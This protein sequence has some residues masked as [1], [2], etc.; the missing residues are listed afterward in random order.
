V[1]VMQMAMAGTVIHLVTQ[2][3][4]IAGMFFTHTIGIHASALGWLVGQYWVSLIALIWQLRRMIL[5]SA[6]AAKAGE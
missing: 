5:E 2:V 3:A 4:L 6:P 1:A